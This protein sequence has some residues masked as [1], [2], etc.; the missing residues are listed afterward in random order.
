MSA[1]TTLGTTSRRKK[2]EKD[3]KIQQTITL[4]RTRLRTQFHARLCIYLRSHPC[5]Q[6]VGQPSKKMKVSICAAMCATTSR[7]R[8][9]EIVVGKFYPYTRFTIDGWRFNEAQLSFFHFPRQNT[10]SGRVLTSS[11]HQISVFLLSAVLP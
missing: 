7:V 2:Q 8:A 9:I 1:P 4:L 3:A 6:R 11:Q 5:I 10:V